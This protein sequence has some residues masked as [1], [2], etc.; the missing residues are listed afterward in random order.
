VARKGLTRIE[1]VAITII[2]VLMAAILVSVMKRTREKPRVVT[3]AMNLRTAFMAVA[4]YTEQSG[5]WMPLDPI[6][7][8]SFKVWPMLYRY[9]GNSFPS[10]FSDLEKCPLLKMMRHTESEPNMSVDWYLCQ[11]DV[12]YHIS[13]SHY[14]PLNMADN[15]HSTRDTW[16]LSYCVNTNALGAIQDDSYPRRYGWRKLVSIKRP[17][18]IVCFSE[19]GDDE[20]SGT[21]PWELVDRNDR[22]NQ[23]GFQLRHA[24]GSNVVYMDGRVQ[25]HRLNYSDPQFGLPPFPQAWVP[26]YQNVPGT[27]DFFAKYVRHP[28]LT[29]SEL[30]KKPATRP[31]KNSRRP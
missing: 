1:V 6:G 3:C 27:A 5:G 31:M 11:Q 4:T 17:S 25:F 21:G 2:I 20:N 13:S 22:N 23:C 9:A 29:A 28:P 15:L 26:D 8:G 16:V 14:S 18:E 19:Q 24:T 12:Y 10:R 30:V 7:A